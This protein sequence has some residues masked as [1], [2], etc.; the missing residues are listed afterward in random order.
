MQTTEGVTAMKN[1]KKKVSKGFTLMELLIAIAIVAVLA[2]IAIPSY[3]HYMKK[4]YYSEVVQTADRFKVAVATCL[5]HTQVA[6]DCDGGSNG[7]PTNVSGITVGQVAGI[8]ITDGVITVT[9]RAVHNIA[10]TDT[11]ILTPD[12]LTNPSVVTWVV[13]GG[14]NACEFTYCT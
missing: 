8:S 2:A 13:T 5:E 4:S 11:L 3:I 7:I 10:A 14:G 1:L 6:A 12:F 9:P